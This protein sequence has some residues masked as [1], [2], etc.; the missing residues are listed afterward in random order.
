MLDA[1]RR[2]LKR[3][4]GQRGRIAAARVRRS[5]STSYYAL[6]HFLSQECGAKIVG[7]Q[8]GLLGRRRI[9]ARVLTHGGMK[10][11]FDR[12][13]GVT[14]HSSVIA[15]FGVPASPVF[16]RDTAKLFIQAQDQRHQADYDLNASLIETEARLLIDR[17]DDNIL[18]WQRARTVAERDFKHAL[19]LLLIVKGRL[20]NDDA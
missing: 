15:Y 5:I 1:S 17:I 20:R 9:F 14:L 11:G 6:F 12:I 19:C 18:A 4:P 16:A 2:L 10:A 13:R 7:T 8:A 3:D